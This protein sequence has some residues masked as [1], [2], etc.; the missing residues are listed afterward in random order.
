MKRFLLLLSVFFSISITAQEPLKYCGADEM[1]ISTLKQNPEIAKAVIQRDMQLE[2]F[3]KQFVADFYAKKTPAAT[4]TIPVVF[5][6]IHNWGAENISDVQIMDGMDV[7][8]KTFRKQ[9]ADTGSI[10]AAFK[11][12]HADC[13]IEFKL[14]KLDPSGNCT[15]G[16]NRIASTLTSTGDHTVKSLIQWPTNKYL[17]VYIVQNA[18]GLA[19]HCVWPADADSIPAWDGIVIGHDYVGTIGTSTYQRSVAFAHE[20]GHYLNLQHIWGGNNVPGFYFYPCAD[21]AKDCSID[22]LVLDTPP[23][24]GWQSCSLTG[25]SCGNAVDNVQNTMDYSYCNRMF[26]FGQK[27]RMQACLNSPIAGRDNLWINSNLIATG[28]LDTALCAA[29]FTSNNRTIC[30]AST[31]PILFTNTSYNGTFTDILWTFPGGTPSS[32]VVANPSIT[33]NSAGVYDVTLKVKNGTDS[34]T[35]TKTNFISVLPVTAN[36]YPFSESFESVSSLN[37]L[38]WFENSFDVE[39]NWMLSNTAAYS[40]STSVMLNNVNNTAGTK[41]EL[42]SK[43]FNVAGATGLNISFKYAFARKDSVNTDRL[44]L[45]ISNSCSATWFQRINLIGTTLE[46]APLQ[47]SSFTPSNMTQWK[48]AAASIPASWLTSTFRFKLVHTSSGG[49]NVYIDDINLDIGAGVEDVSLNNS[50][51]MYPNPA[52]DHLTVEFELESAKKLGIEIRNVL[53]QLLLSTDPENYT[54]GKNEIRLSTNMLKDGIYFVNLTDGN[55]GLKK[56]LVIAR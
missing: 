15:S 47:S 29:N 27:A 43:M 18:A 17:N 45:F 21:T 28:I 24:I 53:G 10:V 40:G 16:I 14:A 33:Y 9:L 4:Y 8:N 41:D 37:G 50:F 34:A 6:V 56:R 55:A 3:T 2:E 13:D 35:I 7:L 31:T 1:R 39:N 46:T 36:A 38:D 5:H 20:C 54:E 19:G 42:I 49:N 11:P 51:G 26:T 23:T 48:Q 44:Q 22:D 30:A 12:I 32:S 52:S 25:A